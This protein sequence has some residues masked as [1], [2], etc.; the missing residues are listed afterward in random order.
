MDENDLQQ[1]VTLLKK[2]CYDRCS[3]CD[4]GDLPECEPEAVW[5]EHPGG[6]ICEAS[7]EWHVLYEVERELGQ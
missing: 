4:D 3:E 6:K 2:R 1:L 7:A 5:W